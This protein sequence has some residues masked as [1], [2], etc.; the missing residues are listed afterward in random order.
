MPRSH[1]RAALAAAIA[2]SGACGDDV[3]APEAPDPSVPMPIQDTGDDM[4]GAL[5]FA[6]DRLAAA[7]PAATAN[8]LASA[9]AASALAA[10]RNDRTGVERGL[11]AARAA[12][13]QLSPTD[14]AADPELEA[15]SLTLEILSARATDSRATEEPRP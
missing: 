11:A 13:R 12:V 5:L 1:L 2:L 6:R 8:Q 10:E 14:A 15:I 9:F 7:L 4:R 3:V